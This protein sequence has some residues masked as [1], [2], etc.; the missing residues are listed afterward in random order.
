VARRPHLLITLWPLSN[1]GICNQPPTDGRVPSRGPTSSPRLA[2]I[3]FALPV[4]CLD[5][6]L[7]ESSESWTAPNRQNLEIYCERRPR[8]SALLA[9]LVRQPPPASCAAALPTCFLRCPSCSRC[10]VGC[11]LLASLSPVAI[12]GVVCSHL[13][14]LRQK[15]FELPDQNQPTLNLPLDH[16]ARICHRAQPARKLRVLF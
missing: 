6:D 2:C 16:I 10:E 7:C 11:V 13:L 1:A 14:T 9:R 3:C 8:L 5:F 12:G 15:T 4:A